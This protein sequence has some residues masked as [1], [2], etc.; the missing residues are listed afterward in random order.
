MNKSVFCT[1]CTPTYNRKELL[2]D[3]YDSLCIQEDKDFEWLVID[4]GSTDNTETLINNFINE[5]KVSIIYKKIKN[6]GKHRAINYGLDFANGQVFAIVD[7]DD[8]LTSNAVKKI[9]EYFDD[10]SKNNLKNLKMAGVVANK[11]YKN[12]EL[13]GTTFNEKTIDA[14]STER[15]KYNIDGDKFEI[16]YTDILKKNRFPEIENEKFMTEAILWTRIAAQGYYFRWYNDNIYVCEYHEGG[17]TDSRE[18]LIANSPLGYALYIKEQVKFGEITLKQK[19]GYY[20]FYYKIRRKNK[21][22]LEIS[23]ELD[24]NI[25]IIYIS[26]IMRRI[27]EKVRSVSEKR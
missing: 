2:K 5:K 4:D 14:K 24:T 26:L 12:N 13:V 10:I 27:I 9:R 17:L 25:F 6:G 11:C 3:L 22:M 8:F 21:K 19:L 16:F 15:R 20:S 18:R 1:V 7:S 23:K